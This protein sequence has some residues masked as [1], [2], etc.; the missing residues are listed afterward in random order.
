MKTITPYAN[1]SESV[2]IAD[3]TIEN[4]TDRVA[5]YGNIDITRDKQGLEQARSL[6]ALFDK[7]VA[8]LESD[9]NLPEQIPPPDAPETVGNP[10]Q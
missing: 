3:L 5:V 9:K 10:F 8:T 7:I 4:R 1:E 2:G 6:K